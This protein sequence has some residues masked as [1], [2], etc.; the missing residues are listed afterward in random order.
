MDGRN[1]VRDSEDRGKIKEMV[2]DDGIVDCEN[3]RCTHKFVRTGKITVRYGSHHRQER[4]LRPSPVD[5]RDD[6]GNVTI[7]KNKNKNNNNRDHGDISQVQEDDGDDNSN[8]TVY[9]LE[10]DK[11]SWCTFDR[12]SLMTT[13]IPVVF[14]IFLGRGFVLETET[15]S[16]KKYTTS[17][18]NNDDI[19]K[20]DTSL[21]VKVSM[22]VL[23]LSTIY[24]LRL[25]FNSRGRRR[26]QE[27][28]EE[29]ILEYVVTVYPMGV[30]LSTRSMTTTGLFRRGGG[31]GGG[32]DGGANERNRGAFI[33]RDRILD[34]RVR[35]IVRP[36][37]VYSSPRLF[38]TGNTK[39]HRINDTVDRVV[40]TIEL[41][42]ETELSYTECDEV[43]HKM[44]K[45][46]GLT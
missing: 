8:S 2:D 33:P 36:H 37:R 5:R 18:D 30:Q 1:D 14:A 44:R 34:C 24:V 21:W 11:S 15:N 4:N 28:E 6:D 40:E 13:M 45:I 31:G 35:E 16:W 7:K 23:I 29:E 27:E 25:S 39:N 10:K 42:P 38:C 3:D 41:F 32:D 22:A 46:L 26:K 43:C 20:D 17:D 9:N 19:D 12:S